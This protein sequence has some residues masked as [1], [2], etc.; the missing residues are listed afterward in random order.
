M[1]EQCVRMPQRSPTPPQPTARSSSETTNPGL[2][3]NT[4]VADTSFQGQTV[5]A[6]RVPASYADLPCD[7]P[8]DNDPDVLVPAMHGLQA[9]AVKAVDTGDVQQSTMGLCASNMRTLPQVSDTW[10][11][12]PCCTARGQHGSPTNTNTAPHSSTSDTSSPQ[13]P[14][15]VTPVM[16]TARSGPKP[17]STYGSATGSAS[18]F[19]YGSA[20]ATG[21]SSACTSAPG[22]ASGSASGYGF[23]STTPPVCMP[24]F[25][26]SPAEKT[27]LPCDNLSTKMGDNTGDVTHPPLRLHD[28]TPLVITSTRR[29]G[30]EGS[31]GSQLHCFD[32]GGAAPPHAAAAPSEHRC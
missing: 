6:V 1:L 26:S 3:V 31:T 11:E 8:T 12:R 20:S 28:T 7:A 15:A 18:G 29:P 16:H 9:S 4:Q 10:S 25:I 19:A 2:R 13:T 22:S 30:E 5:D 17:G 27:T 14:T 24:A 32:P 21:S 23:A